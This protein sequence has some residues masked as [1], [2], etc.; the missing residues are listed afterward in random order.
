MPYIAKTLALMTLAVVS[1]SPA[2]AS[3]RHP[4]YHS[5]NRHQS[6]LGDSKDD[7]AEAKPILSEYNASQW[8]SNTGDCLRHEIPPTS[9][10][11][12]FIRDGRIYD[13]LCLRTLAYLVEPEE[14]ATCRVQ[15]NCHVARGY[16]NDCLVN[17]SFDQGFSFDFEEV[18]RQELEWK[19]YACH[20]K[21]LDQCGRDHS[22]WWRSLF[23][24]SRGDCRIRR[25]IGKRKQD[26]TSDNWVPWSTGP[27]GTV[28]DND[29]LSRLANRL[30]MENPGNCTQTNTYAAHNARDVPPVEVPKTLVHATN[31]LGPLPGL[32]L[33]TTVTDLNRLTATPVTANIPPPEKT[34]ADIIPVPLA[35]NIPDLQKGERIDPRPPVHK[36]T[37]ALGAI[38]TSL[39]LVARAQGPPI[40]LDEWSC[41]WNVDVALPDSSPRMFD[42]AFGD[43][44]VDNIPLAVQRILEGE[45]E[46]VSECGDGLLEDKLQVV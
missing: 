13:K 27:D 10:T 1:A 43:A 39:P 23:P 19:K 17:L 7:H 28:Y 42:A 4:R 33:P 36:P 24:S 14:R 22:F 41:M 11:T 40:D 38:P 2:L 16:D 29:C 6:F 25:R 37:E 30:G 5:P 3:R 18:R 31:P 21:T 15:G 45:L 26:V 20:E 34:A 32:E 9:D 44:T 8:P 46:Y 12:W 35:S